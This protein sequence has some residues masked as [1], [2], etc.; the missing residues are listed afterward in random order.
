MQWLNVKMQKS[1]KS[2]AIAGCC[3]IGSWSES[4]K[5]SGLRA[6]AHAVSMSCCPIEVGEFKESEAIPNNASNDSEQAGKAMRPLALESDKSKQHIKQ[7]G[8]PKLPANGMLGVAKEVADLEGLLDLFEE[9]FDAPSAS[10]QIT[11]AGSSPLKVI[12]QEDH[13]GP[14]PINLDPCLDA[15]QSLG[16]LPT[17]LVSD[18]SNLVVADDVAHWL[19]Q[20]LATDVVA[21]VVLSSGDPEDATL[22]QIEEVSEVDVGLV[23]DGYLARLQPCAQ[24]QCPGVVVMGG[25]LD[26]G[27]RRE[28]SLQVQPQM[29]LRGRLAAPVLGPVHAVGDQCN[30]GGVDGMDRP[31]KAAWQAAVATRRSELRIEALEVTEDRPKQF[32]HHVT[33][34]VLVRIREGV[35][36]WRHRPTNRSKFSSMV[37]KAVANVV[38]PNRMSELS[39]QKTHHVAPRS[40]GSGLLFHTVLLRKF[41]SQMRGDEFTKLMQCAAVVLGRRYLFHASDSLVGIRRRPTF[42][43]VL[44]SNSQIYPVG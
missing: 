41:C 32:L 43:S 33:V 44:N 12:G 10:I 31:L 36:A 27:K 5:I 38:H 21:Q 17:G 6:G 1:L 34:A 40:K 19:A 16:I 26:N 13:G 35:A 7:H 4:R 2:S 8:C 39:E 22:A 29:H 28:K 9:G 37:T 18:Q 23:E 3:P 25:F 30:R 14:L 11:D 24:G 42:L 20:P 15:A